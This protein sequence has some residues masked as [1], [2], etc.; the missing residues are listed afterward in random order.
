MVTRTGFWGR[1]PL[2]KL[3]NDIDDIYPNYPV[4]VDDGVVW[5]ILSA[6]PTG[7]IEG[8]FVEYITEEIEVGCL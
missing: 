7:R 5:A 3:H 4:I 2:E 8:D 1:D 6:I